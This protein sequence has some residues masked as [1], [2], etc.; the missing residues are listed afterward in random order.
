MCSLTQFR[1]LAKTLEYAVE[2]SASFDVRF[3]RYS[4]AN[5]K[6]VVE[7]TSDVEDEDYE[8]DI[9]FYDERIFVY[10]SDETSLMVM[11]DSIQIYYRCCIFDEFL[12]SDEFDIGEIR[13]PKYFSIDKLDID[14]I[15]V[16]EDIL[17]IKIKGGK[18]IEK[19]IEITI[20]GDKQ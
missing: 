8:L 16:N 20:K 17:S 3:G 11:K 13:C 5:S 2:R 12:T 9:S 19:T 15:K 4:F 7:C 1:E 18:T 6:V 14:E 10:L